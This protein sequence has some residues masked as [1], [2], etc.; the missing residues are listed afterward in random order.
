MFSYNSI[1]GALATLDYS[2]W[3]SCLLVMTC[4]FL[5]YLGIF[6]ICHVV[7]VILCDTYCSLSA[8]EKVFWDLAATRAVFGIQCTFAGLTALLIDPVLSGDKIGAQ[9]NWSWFIILIATGFFLFE[10]LALHAFN[11]LFWTCDVFLAVHHFFAFMGYFGC[12]LYSTAGHY[13]A[14]VVLL[15]EMSTPFTCMSWMLLK[16]GWSDTLFWKANQWLMIHMFHCRIVLTY[17]IWWVCFC[18]WDR[19]VRLTPSLYLAFFMIGLTLL[20]FVMNP[21]WTYKKTHQLLNPVDWNFEA[22]RKSS[23][24]CKKNGGCKKTK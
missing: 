17:H 24:L 23:V 1:A 7:S 5:V 6:L 14:M 4:G 22:S 15:L 16:A 21:Y 12:V 8:K 19:L 20:T 10:N 2:T 3:N 11:I 18:N 13:L 9:Q